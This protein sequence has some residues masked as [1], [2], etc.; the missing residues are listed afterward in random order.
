MKV[1]NDLD[2]IVRLK[3]GDRE[4]FEELVHKYQDKIHNLCRY[5][6]RDSQDCQDAAQDV[7]IKAYKKLAD[8][9]PDEPF[10]Y[11]WLYRIAINTC[12][13]YNKRSYPKPLEDETLVENVASSD[14]SPEQLYGLGFLSIPVSTPWQINL[15][16]AFAKEATAAA[17]RLPVSVSAW[18]TASALTLSLM[19][20]ALASFFMG[21][22]T[23]RM[24]PADILRKL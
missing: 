13:D 14:P 11:A 12:F 21:R 19:A 17:V 4:A 23:S 16:P 24:K 2:L 3:R 8:F 5:T 6:L 10:L 1:G 18:L 7:F 20:G 9:R 15:T 22:R